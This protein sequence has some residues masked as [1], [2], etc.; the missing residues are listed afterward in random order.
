MS[1][2]I[3]TRNLTQVK[4]GRAFHPKEEELGVSEPTNDH[5]LS[6]DNFGSR[7]EPIVWSEGQYGQKACCCQPQPQTRLR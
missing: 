4:Q 2:S 5:R 6:N 3:Q 7:L 1:Y